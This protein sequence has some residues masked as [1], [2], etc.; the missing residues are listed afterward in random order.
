MVLDEESL[1]KNGVFVFCKPSWERKYGHIFVSFSIGLV[2]ALVLK[3]VVNRNKER[4]QASNVAWVK[5][6]LWIATPSM[7]FLGTISHFYEMTLNFPSFLNCAT[8]LDEE[9]TPYAVA[10]YVTFTAHVFFVVRAF[11]LWTVTRYVEVIATVLNV[12]LLV[13]DII[14]GCL[15]AAEE[16]ETNDYYHPDTEGSITP[17]KSSWSY[18][19]WTIITISTVGFGD[20]TPS[21]IKGQFVILV[22]I[23]IFVAWFNSLAHNLQEDLEEQVPFHRHK[24]KS[25][26]LIGGRNEDQLSNF[27]D[28]GKNKDI[29]GHR[30]ESVFVHV[31][32]S[33]TG[34][35]GIVR[36]L[37]MKPI[38]SPTKEE[39]IISNAC[40]GKPGDTVFFLQDPF[41]DPDESD[42]HTLD[43]I[44]LLKGKASDAV[45]YVEMA[46]YKH[47]KLIREI[48]NWNN[49]A[50]DTCISYEY[51]AA[52]ILALSVNTRL[53]PFFIGHG[54]EKLFTGRIERHHEKFTK[55]VHHEYTQSGNLLLGAITDDGE[56]LINPIKTQ[57]TWSHILLESEQEHMYLPTE[58]VQSQHIYSKNSTKSKEKAMIQ[59]ITISQISVKN[60]VSDALN[61]ALECHG[62]TLTSYDAV[63]YIQVSKIHKDDA[64]DNTWEFLDAMQD[65]G[66]VPLVSTLEH[67]HDICHGGIDNCKCGIYNISKLIT[68]L[69]V[70]AHKER[71][72]YK[73]WMKLIEGNYLEAAEIKQ[74]C[75]YRDLFAHLVN[76][77]KI[78]IAVEVTGEGGR[79]VPVV[80]PPPFLK[81]QQG[82][83][84]LYVK[85]LSTDVRE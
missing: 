15:R 43:L 6:F 31:T 41:L 25:C 23:A 53:T 35:S 3:Q 58:D 55:A 1:E 66:E 5:N 78:P 82:D 29:T 61:Q 80:H 56:I 79:Q 13:Q 83:I 30:L 76:S 39:V 45:L 47:Q 67:T 33:D 34:V 77:Q 63:A 21:T 12:A 46:K 18:A 71:S 19:Y 28:Y 10:K 48:S 68:K 26:L 85:K 74:A 24:S 69:L 70:L 37:G 27:K 62:F 42:L 75:V 49:A 9:L 7:A 64:A 59:P 32:P 51:M 40:P 2:L 57:S 52:H 72:K 17:M 22:T 81:L 16:W 4:L 20:L 44:R 84:V 60:G 54:F 36:N 8:F 38:E 73:F 65:I 50:G 11:I 14:G